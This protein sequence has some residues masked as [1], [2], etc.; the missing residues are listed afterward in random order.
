MNITEMYNELDKVLADTQSDWKLD[1]LADVA[2]QARNVTKTTKYNILC[3]ILCALYV[4]KS[5]PTEE[6]D[7]MLLDIENYIKLEDYEDGS[8]GQ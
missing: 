5:I 8:N 2:M 3:S 7:D 6:I 4:A 1:D